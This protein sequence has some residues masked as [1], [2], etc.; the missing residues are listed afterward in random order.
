MPSLLLLEY[1]DVVV[2]VAFV[3]SPP[4]YQSLLLLLAWV[5]AAATVPAGA[6]QLLTL[7]FACGAP[8]LLLAAGA[9][10]FV[11]QS[12]ASAPPSSVWIAV[13]LDGAEA[14]T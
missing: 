14:P 10:A 8:Q 13:A 1:M 4:E 11:P 2:S 12:H 9:G 3:V 6:A 5:S 7:T